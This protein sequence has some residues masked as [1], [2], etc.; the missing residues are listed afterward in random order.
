MNR[1]ICSLLV[2]IGLLFLGGLTLAPYAPTRKKIAADGTF[3]LRTENERRF[4][5]L[6]ANWFPYLCFA[7]AAGSFGWTVYL[8]AAG[9]VYVVRVKCRNRAT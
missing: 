8:V 6:Q 3:T 1:P 2:A 7:G 4:A 5:G 9:L